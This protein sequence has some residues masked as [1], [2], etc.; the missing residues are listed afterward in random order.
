ML[1]G[2]AQCSDA[3]GRG[4]FFAP[5]V[6]ADCTHAMSVMTDETFGP[7]IAICAVDSEAEAVAVRRFSWLTLPRGDSGETCAH[8]KLVSPV[9][10]LPLSD[11]QKMND[12]VYG[13]TASVFTKSEALAE[14]VGAQLNVGTVFMN[15]CDYV[16]PSLPW[17]GRGDSGKGISL[18]PFGFNALTRTKGYNFRVPAKL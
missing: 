2:G 9:L 3:A 16:D 1:T 14:R 7:V 12:S 11:D 13:L 5:T 4:R 8:S 15:R 17:S 18:S 6:V 10:F